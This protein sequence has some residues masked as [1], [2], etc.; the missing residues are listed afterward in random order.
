VAEVQ[1]G[2]LL[3]LA[4]SVLAGRYSGTPQPKTAHASL[5]AV[6]RDRSGPQ[7]S[8][9]RTPPCWA[10]QRR[11]DSATL[12]RS[13]TIGP[14]TAASAATTRVAQSQW[15]WKCGPN[16]ILTPVLLPNSSDSTVAQPPQPTA[17]TITPAQR[18]AALGQLGQAKILSRQSEH[19]R[20]Y[21]L[22]TRR[23]T[24]RGVAP[25]AGRMVRPGAYLHKR[26]L[27]TYVPRPP[28]GFLSY[29]LTGQ[30][31]TIAAPLLRPLVS[32]RYPGAKYD[33]K[34]KRARHEYVFRS[35]RRKTAHVTGEERHYRRG[36]S[37][38]DRRVVSCCVSLG[39]WRGRTETRLSAR[40]GPH[41]WLEVAPVDLGSRVGLTKTLK[42][43]IDRNSQSAKLLLACGLAVRSEQFEPRRA[44]RTLPAP[45][46]VGVFVSTE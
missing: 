2:F 12:C 19:V 36:I 1:A 30:V 37:R 4:L 44:H 38:K 40:T 20:L 8:G 7:Q 45:A 18:L 32:A 13:Q 35:L 29:F 42:R 9:S 27:A 39:D 41:L 5:A 6:E 46:P 11:N 33:A 24:S 34:A 43:A 16:H 17:K 23:L 28:A 22:Q 25:V 10:H 21:Y 26:V 31:V 3:G 15:P 14:R